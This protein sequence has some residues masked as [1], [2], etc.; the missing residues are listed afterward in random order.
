VKGRA[1]CYSGLTYTICKPDPLLRSVDNKFRFQE[2]TK[3][4]FCE[5]GQRMNDRAIFFL[6]RQRGRIIAFASAIVHN[7]VLRDSC[8]G[9]DYTVALKYHLYFVTWRDSI[10]WA[11]KNGFHTYHSGP[12]NYDPKYHLRMILEPLDLYVCS[13][14]GWLNLIF[15]PILPLLEPTRH[16]R[17]IRKFANANELW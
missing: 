15:K 13:P 14:Y 6:W 7:G 16:D 4:Y 17:V 11:L 1:S 12:L 5:L 3:S 8:I 10:V 9:L 2:L